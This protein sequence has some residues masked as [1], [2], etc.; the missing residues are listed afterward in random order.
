MAHRILT[1]VIVFC[2]VISIGFTASAQSSGSKQTTVSKHRDVE[3]GSSI[4]SDAARLQEARVA[5]AIQV[6]SFLADE[7]RLYKDESLSVRF[8]A[9]AAD[10]LWSADRERAR[11]LFVRAWDT[12][13]IVDKE[14]QRRNKE[15]R[16]RF[17]S[18]RGGTGFIPAPPNLRAEVLRLAYVHEPTLAESFLVK[19]EEDDLR[20]EQNA[21]TARRWDPTEPPATIARRLQLARQLLESGD[22]EKAIRVAQAGL[23]RVTAQG[24]IFLVLLRQKNAGFADQIFNSLL[25]RSSDD[26]AA[27]ATSVSLLSTY[28]FTPSVFVTST[29]NGLL[30]NPWTEELPPP[31]LSPELR[32]KFFSVASQILL[33]PLDPAALEQ[34]SAGLAGTYF[35]IK[36]LL[37][38]FEQ[39]DASMALALQSRLNTLA[40]GSEDLIPVSQRGFVN[41]GF[42]SNQQKEDDPEDALS[43]LDGAGTK[44]RNHLYAMAARGAAMK[45]DPRAREFAAKIEDTDLKKN[46]STFVDFILVSKALEAKHFEKAL[47]LARTGELSHLQRAWAY[48]EI[49]ALLKS[50]APDDSMT[51]ILEAGREAERI[52][53]TSPECAE[54]WVAVARRAVE[55]DPTGK[56]Y[57]ALEAIKAV[58]RASDYTGEE[59]EISVGFQS[60]NNIIKMQ[61]AAPTISLSALVARLAEDDIYRAVATAKNVTSESPRAL[62]IL[63]GARV[64]FERGV[65]TKKR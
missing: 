32:A 58:N 63:A 6:V 3:A 26:P 52:E 12:A 39:N 64:A 47:Q 33:R 10:I 21:A 31:Q 7:A 37:T 45:N 11:A 17:L 57:K 36:R 56:W 9:R 22:T 50:S 48:S 19:M 30:M 4:E 20:E 28:V 49:A 23:N 35:T 27:D 16:E 51:L 54:A 55:I 43:R 62:A 2:G 13:Q 53:V 34:T 14:G 59:S 25:D 42:K 44:Q 15:E 24:V 38:L 8:Q 46:V 41:A 29:R 65:A 60:Q 18:K 5:F 40:P 61:V 1:S